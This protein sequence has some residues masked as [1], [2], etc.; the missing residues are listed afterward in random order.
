VEASAERTDDGEDRPPPPT[1]KRSSETYAKARHPDWLRS[2]CSLVSQLTS[3]PNTASTTHLPRI[4][5][6]HGDE[7]CE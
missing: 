5:T 6:H 3:W 4:C 7:L 2:D 1:L